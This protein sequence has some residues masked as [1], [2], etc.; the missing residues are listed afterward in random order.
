MNL[1]LAF[2]QSRLAGHGPRHKCIQRSLVLENLCFK[3]LPSPDGYAEIAAEPCL[4]GGEFRC[5][6]VHR[7][8]VLGGGSDDEFLAQ[9]LY[10]EGLCRLLGNRSF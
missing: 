10:A 5:L 1:L 6:F 2:Q 7:H 4:L 3:R 8:V 9:R